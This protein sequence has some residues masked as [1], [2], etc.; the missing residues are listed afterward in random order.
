MHSSLAHD[1]HE[2]QDE[3]VVHPNQRANTAM[4]TRSERLT[5]LW[6][7]RSELRD[8]VAS[9]DGSLAPAVTSLTDDEL[10]A[11][12]VRVRERY[13]ALW[14]PSISRAV[15][16]EDVLVRRAAIRFGDAFMLD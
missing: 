3:G 14:H 5:L 8:V 11:I 9:V 4:P 12:A 6:T 7:T 10:A 15:P 13:F 2:W 1:R 16:P